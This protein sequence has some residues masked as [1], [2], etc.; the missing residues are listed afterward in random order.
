MPDIFISADTT[1]NTLVVRELMTR[2]LF[3]A[4]VIDNMQGLLSNYP[5]ADAYL[6]QYVVSDKDFSD[7]IKYVS[8]TLQS[9]DPREILLSAPYIKT[10]L[11]ANSAR[12]KWGDEAYVKAINANDVVLKKAIEAV[13]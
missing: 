4:Y 9:T 5:S 13:R 6:K 3:T 2:Q 8:P 7:F 11:K 10:L 1:Q 12:F